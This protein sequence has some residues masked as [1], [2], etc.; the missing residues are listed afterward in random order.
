MP[1]E[2]E[3][4]VLPVPPFPVYIMSL[5]SALIEKRH[6]TKKVTIAPQY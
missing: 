2:Q 6:N 4:T 5:I 1:V 3:V